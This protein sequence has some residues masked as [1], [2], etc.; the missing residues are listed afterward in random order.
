MN[1]IFFLPI[2]GVLQARN[3]LKTLFVF[4][5]GMG[6]SA[7]ATESPT[8]TIRVCLDNQDYPPYFFGADAE[9]AEVSGKGMMLDLINM[10]ANHTGVAMVFIRKPWRR[11]L[12]DIKSGHSDASGP[13]IWSKARALGAHFPTDSQ[14]NAVSKSALWSVD[15]RVFSRNEAKLSWDGQSFRGIRY[16]V[17]APLGHVSHKKLKA[18]G[19]LPSSSFTV[20]EGLTMVSRGFLDGFV[21]ESLSGQFLMVQ[22]GVDENVSAQAVPFLTTELYLAFSHQF[23]AKNPTLVEGFYRTFADYGSEWRRGLIEHYI[24]NRS[25]IDK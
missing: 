3:L 15:Y 19:V 11:C 9:R 6:I 2:G 1:C 8:A 25:E 7:Q 21:N 22:L 5:C 17:A 4:I 10:S 20:I 12:A 13:L 16:G 14:G 18:M 24:P 23:T